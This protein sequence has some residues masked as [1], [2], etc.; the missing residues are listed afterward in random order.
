M[1]TAY[2]RISPHGSGYL[3]LGADGP[4]KIFRKFP[5]GME[6]YYYKWGA[7]GEGFTP[8]TREKYEGVYRVDNEI[9]QKIFSPKDI[10]VARLVVEE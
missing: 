5:A 7:L 10:M 2:G 1:T 6:F 4:D 9:M 3:S 8:V